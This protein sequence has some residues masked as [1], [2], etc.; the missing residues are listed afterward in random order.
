MRVVATAPLAVDAAALL[1]PAVRFEAPAAGRMDRAALL[2]AVPG[3]D[4]LIAL[5]TDR[6]DG[7]LLE[8]AGPQLRVVAN[9]AVGVDNVDLAACTRRGV[10]VTNTPDVLTEAT[11]DLTF[12]LLLAAARRIVEGDALVRGGRWTGWEPTQHLGL[13][14]AGATLGLVGLGRIGTAVARRAGGF[15]MTVIH[16]SRSGGVPF[17][18]LLVTSDFVSLHCPLD[19]TTRHL[20]DAAALARMKPTA[21]LVNTARGA[22]VDEAALAEALAAG[23]IAGAGLDVFEAEPRVHPGL[24]ASPKVVLAPHAGSATTSARSRMGAICATAVRAVLEGQRPP[25]VVNPEVYD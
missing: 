10:V 8:V 5:L 21:I 3:A 1:G 4:G 14:V 20:I 6:V 15:G 12:A 11:A 16:H 24:L 9:H 17:D 13:D 23:R 7:E 22:C 25:T 2:A 19:A 18:E